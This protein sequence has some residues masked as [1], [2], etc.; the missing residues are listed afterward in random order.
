MTDSSPA[1]EMAKRAGR[2]AL[3][4]VTERLDLLRRDMELLF[5]RQAEVAASAEQAAA[6]THRLEI[7]FDRFREE[8]RTETEAA[9]ARAAEALESRDV[10]R[11]VSDSLLAELS[12]DGAPT[13]I[14]TALR[15]RLDHGLL[16]AE[17]IAAE[18][19]QAL[20]RQ[21]GDL[22]ASTRLTQSLVE[23]AL[24]V[25][26]ARSPDG[27]GPGAT[28]PGPPQPAIS[29]AGPAPAVAPSFAH[30][31]PSFDLLYRAFEDRHRGSAEMILDRQQTDY[32]DLFTALPHPELPIADLGCGRGELVRLLDEAGLAS[33][34]VDANHGQIADGDERL[35]VEDDL[36]HWL[37]AQQD[38]SHRAVVAMHVVEHLPLD[39]QIRLVFEAR[40]VLAD[41]GLLVLETPNLFSISTAA[42]NFWVDP[43]HQRPVH[44]LFMEF[45]ADEAGFAPVELRPLHALAANFDGAPDAPA[46]AQNLD[47]LIFGHGDIAL[48]A[49]R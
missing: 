44:P 10:E 23:R 12:P 29:S 28:E 38:G 36:F 16:H 26:V 49:W 15:D 19:R 17:A 41:G 48:I 1:R 32:L 24:A 40:R 43:T 8:V 47:Q 20:D 18:T 31:T 27:E 11:A 7:Y 6:A 13:D 35:F 45:L 46:L 4:P 2:R 14:G 3:G 39:L 5:G 33:V 42:T 21:S 25:S 30:A 22:R 9:A 37:D 34:G